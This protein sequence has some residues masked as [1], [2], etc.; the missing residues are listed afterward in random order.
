MILLK[1]SDARV[2]NWC[3][4]YFFVLRLPFGAV[5]SMGPN[6][7]LSFVTTLRSK[8]KL[9]LPKLNPWTI[10]CPINFISC[11]L[12]SIFD[13]S[14]LNHF[15]FLFTLCPLFERKPREMLLNGCKAYLCTMYIHFTYLVHTTGH[16]NIQIHGTIVCVS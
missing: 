2:S 6:P 10:Q 4:F 5:D 12:P 15:Y 14:Q 3:T 8:L 7:N 11:N 9:P 1:I 16:T 13:E